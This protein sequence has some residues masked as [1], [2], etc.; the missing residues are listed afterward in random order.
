MA[1]VLVLVVVGD[2]LGGVLLFGH[3]AHLHSLDEDGLDDNSRGLL[4][5]LLGTLAGEL[6]REGLERSELIDLLLDD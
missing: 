2:I 3:L 5:F 4:L 6:S 1:T